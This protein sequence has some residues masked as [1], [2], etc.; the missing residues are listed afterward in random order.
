MASSSAS[1][2]PKYDPHQS[3]RLPPQHVLKPMTESTT[4]EVNRVM[5]RLINRDYCKRYFNLPVDHVA[6][7]LFNYPDIVTKPMDLGTIGRK[8]AEDKERDWEA[9]TYKYLEDF[10]ADVRQVW[11][12]ALVFNQQLAHKEPHDVFKAAAIL[13]HDFEK[14]MAELHDQLNAEAPPCPK[15]LRAK[16]LLADI[17]RSPLSE[18][19]RR[20]RDWRALGDDYVD[21]L[22]NRM[23]P[24]SKPEDLDAVQAWLEEQQRAADTGDGAADDGWMQEFEDR[25]K[26]VCDNAVAYNEN[27]TAVGAFA[28]SPKDRTAPGVCARAL[29]VGFDLRIKQFKHAPAP[30]ERGQRAPAREGWPS[31]DD[32]QEL[33]RDLN[34]LEL[35]DQSRVGR[36]IA[37]LC[38]AAV[39]PRDDKALPASKRVRVD[40]DQVDLNTFQR[41]RELAD[42][43]AQKA[44]ENQM[45]DEYG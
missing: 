23:R 44:F 7:N 32:K 26:T 8:L 10:A 16:L 19:F 14:V 27:R 21:F 6:L 33:Y 25:V 34:D 9:K 2:A 29:K 1:K 3:T 42:E 20:E 5:K 43:R 24:A 18:W 11:K 22:A 28:K 15:L 41:A 35:L 45:Q 17:R 38:P 36:L 39:V 37:E 12:N 30:L 13:A 40:L 31:F 4:D